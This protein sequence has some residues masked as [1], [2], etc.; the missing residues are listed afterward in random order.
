MEYQFRIKPLPWSKWIVRDFVK[1]DDTV[2]CER[3]T[4]KI[5]YK[6]CEMDEE[7]VHERQSVS[8]YE[9]EE[10]CEIVNMNPYRIKSSQRFVYYIDD[11]TYRTDTMLCT[12]CL[13]SWYLADQLFNVN[14]PTK[15]REC[16]KNS[17]KQIDAHERLQSILTN[18][19]F[20]EA[21]VVN[22]QPFPQALKEELLTVTWNPDRRNLFGFTMPYDELK[23]LKESG[24]LMP[25]NNA[26]AGVRHADGVVSPRTV[27]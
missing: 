10:R 8:I 18:P 7:D 22:T 14:R 23:A 9:V 13:Y 20:K 11:Q 1:M 12:K 19:H 2:H 21:F 24:I 15:C 16:R 3:R 26:V 5:G 17:V 27:S 25:P 4:R 6:R